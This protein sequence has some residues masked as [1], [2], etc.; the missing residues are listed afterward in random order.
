MRARRTTMLALVPML[1]IALIGCPAP[2]EREDVETT[3]EE[4]WEDVTP[5]DEGATFSLDAMRDS[6]VEGDVQLTG[7]AQ[8]MT[9]A[10]TLD[11]APAQQQYTAVLHTGTCDRPGQM[12]R[13][14]STVTAP[15]DD[16]GFMDEG[17][18][19]T[20]TDDPATTEQQQG[21]RDG[22]LQ[23]D[24][25]RATVSGQDLQP[26]QQYV[27]V[28]HGMDQQTVAC[29]EFPDD[30]QEQVG[31]DEGMTGMQDRGTTGQDPTTI[32]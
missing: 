25:A 27:I 23:A 32:G 5:T 28:L 24:T 31:S 7:T 21:I 10:I 20:T 1:S 17:A 18:D 11:E 30:W 16:G 2:E 26:G 12:V 15:A 29:G 4:T 22:T 8:Q 19:A 6:G 9:V 3:A 14:L 13:E